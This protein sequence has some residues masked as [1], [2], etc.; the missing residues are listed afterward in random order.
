MQA[1]QNNPTASA[2]FDEFGPVIAATIVEFAPAVVRLAETGTMTEKRI[3]GAKAAHGH[4]QLYLSN[5]RGKIGA[6]AR[7]GL[8]SHGIEKMG[9]DARHGNYLPIAQA[10]A[11]ILGRAVVIPNRAVFDVQAVFYG[12]DLMTLKDGGY[13]TN[14]KTGEI[15]E[16]AKRKALVEAINLLTAVK[17][18]SDAL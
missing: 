4:A 14:K 2:A 17:A 7:T 16:T 5:M 6:V 3:A 9:K 10:L 1:I 12:A 18:V 15:T 13:S 11:V 8:A